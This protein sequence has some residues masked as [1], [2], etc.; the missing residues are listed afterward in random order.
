MFAFIFISIFILVSDGCAIA[1]GP[2]DQRLRHD[3][4][5]LP[6]P[7]LPVKLGSAN[8]PLEKGGTSRL[9]SQL[10]GLLT[11]F[12][13]WSTNSWRGRQPPP[14]FRNLSYLGI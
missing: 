5:S 13:S 14:A 2:R 8:S 7:F 4:K 11:D 10:A 1:A 12:I 3:G 6:A 9:A